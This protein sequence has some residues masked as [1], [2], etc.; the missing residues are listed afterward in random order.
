MDIVTGSTNIGVVEGAEALEL[1][2]YPADLHP[3]PLTR[4]LGVI[5]EGTAVFAMAVAVLAGF[6]IVAV[7]LADIFERQFLDT[8]IFGAEEFSRFAFL[9]LIWMGVALAV[10][11]SA[12][13]VL[14][15]GTDNGPWW[16]RA[17]LRGLAMGSLVDPAHL[18]LLGV[19]PLRARAGIARSGQ[20]GDGRADVDG[21]PVDARRV[22]V[23]RHPVPVHR[24]AVA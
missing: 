12:V 15:I 17:S 21:D 24:R 13:T 1:G 16:W 11:R 23:H 22:R 6:A 10:R 20:P 4:V 8:T 14:T 7:T 19:D 2:P 3:R 5:A 18:L 9:W